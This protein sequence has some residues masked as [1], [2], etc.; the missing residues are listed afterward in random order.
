M[1]INIDIFNTVITILFSIITSYITCKAT[2][3]ENRKVEQKNM[4]S[5]IMNN[6]KYLEKSIFL[7]IT[8]ESNIEFKKLREEM[9]EN[10]GNFIIFPNDIQ[11]IIMN[12]YKDINY[13]GSEF[14]KNKENIINLLR[15][16]YYK[17]EDYGVKFDEKYK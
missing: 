5:T 13:S 2:F 9:N 16:L 8:D 12:I 15:S 11:N 1:N 3:K 14:I 7:S 6:N 4:I 10:I 17:M